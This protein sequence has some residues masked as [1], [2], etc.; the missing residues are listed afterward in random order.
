VEKHRPDRADSDVFLAV[1][2]PR[3]SE[4]LAAVWRVDLA[5]GAGG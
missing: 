5:S 4:L 2:G 3:W 1:I